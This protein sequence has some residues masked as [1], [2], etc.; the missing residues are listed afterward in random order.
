M[1]R[2]YKSLTP[3]TR[4]IIGSGIIAY[5]GIGLYLSDKAE[6]RLGLVPSDKDKLNEAPP[7]IITVETLERKK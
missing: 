7:Q 2:W 1:I 5:A 6:E 3:K 4:I